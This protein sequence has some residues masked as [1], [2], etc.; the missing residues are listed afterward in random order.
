MT[1]TTARIRKS[2]GVVIRK[3]LLDQAQLKLGDKVDVKIHPDGAITL[4]PIRDHV[5][6]VIKQTMKNY[7]RTMNRLAKP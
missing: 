4:T 7:A 5:S 6:N 1:K 3:A 2:G